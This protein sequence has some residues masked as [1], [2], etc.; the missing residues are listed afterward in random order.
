ML[1]PKLQDEIDKC[2][3]IPLTKVLNT[4]DAAM[5]LHQLFLTA[6]GI[7]YALAPATLSE[8][9]KISKLILGNARQLDSTQMFAERIAVDFNS[10]EKKAFKLI[11]AF[12]KIYEQLIPIVALKNIDYL[13]GV[14]RESFGI[15]T[16][17]FEELSDFYAKSY[18]WI[19]DNINIVVG[20][21]NI[22]VRGSYIDC[23][24]GKGYDNILSTG[25]H[26]K[27][28][29]V[30]EHEPFSRPTSCLKNRIRNA[31][32]HFDNEIDY[33]S[34][35]IV[36]TDNHAGRTREEH[37]YLIDFAVLC[38]ENYSFII[39]LLELV[40]N[41]RKLS[42]M[43]QG[44]I[45]NNISPEAKKPQHERGSSKPGRN[46]PCPCGSGE[47]YKRCCGLV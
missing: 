1:Y 33:V 8:Y 30:G 16:A 7:S 29:Y 4:L 26:N 23:V 17:N 25:K 24:N 35:K 22:A 13:D 28:E 45:P 32:Q 40:Y 44:V 14:D 21:N 2:D 27:L 15:M 37:L 36:F 5:A 11:D 38:L 20:L 3:W 19:L 34:Q 41:L 9:I 31:I 42:F 6:S 47:K 39:Y 10:I 18:E 12:A 43:S 46:A